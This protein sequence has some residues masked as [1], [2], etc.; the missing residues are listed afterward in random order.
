MA[1]IQHIS[2]C[3]DLDLYLSK[4]DTTQYNFIGYIWHEYGWFPFYFNELF[5]EFFQKKQGP[6]VATCLPGHEFF[7]EDKVD[8]LLVLDN[9]VNTTNAYVDSK[10]TDLLKNNSSKIKDKGIAF[11]LTVRNFDENEFDAVL[12]KY[13]FRNILYPIGKTK[14]WDHVMFPNPQIKY[15]YASGE[16]GNLILPDN[17][18]YGRYHKNNKWTYAWD[19]S[20][21]YH[22][23]IDRIID[24][25]YDVIFVKNSW[26]TRT[27]DNKPSFG[28]LDQNLFESI[29]DHYI[30]KKRRLFVIDD[31]VEYNIKDNDYVSK[32]TMK[33]FLDVKKLL[34]IIYH[35]NTFI[36]AATGFADLSLYYCPNTNLILLDDMQRKLSWAEHVLEK[37]NK[38]VISINSSPFDEAE[39]LK[40]TTHLKLG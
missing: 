14:T 37:F 11:W 35:A 4:L 9:F 18:K 39:F 26:K 20:K 27:S 31:L 28:H 36:T 13:Q 1:N 25:N 40:L 30:E 19:E 8:E 29:C 16:V 2:S 15:Q 10:E 38:S 5:S 24:G 32:I 3:K 22:R 7:Y 23:H 34:Q 12:H 6:T 21:H 33:G 17:C